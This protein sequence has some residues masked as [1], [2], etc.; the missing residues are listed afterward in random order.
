M[1]TPGGGKGGGR[2]LWAL[3]NLIQNT[4]EYSARLK[5]LSA[6]EASLDAKL[7]AVKTIDEAHALRAQAQKAAGEATAAL[8]NAQAQARKMI[9]DAKAGAESM[10]QSARDKA[11]KAAAHELRQRQLSEQLEGDIHA[12]ELR[13]KEKEASL[14]KRAADLAARERA[15]VQR[16]ED[17]EARARRIAEIVGA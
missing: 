11:E 6:R 7:E 14:D 1:I 8:S 17:L 5:E 2:D 13:L 4:E 3:L 16:A 9:E 10:E 12:W 15:A